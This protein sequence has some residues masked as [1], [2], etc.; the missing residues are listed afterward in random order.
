MLS[1]FQANP[2]TMYTPEMLHNDLVATN[3]INENT[4]HQFRAFNDLNKVAIIKTSKNITNYGRHS[5]Y[6]F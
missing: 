4:L 3:D 6:G 1:Y 5:I 2:Y